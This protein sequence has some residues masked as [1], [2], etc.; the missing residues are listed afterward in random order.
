MDDQQW[1]TED[2][3]ET[4]MIPVFTDSLFIL[5]KTLR[6]KTVYMTSAE[7]WLSFCT[8]ARVTPSTTDNSYRELQDKPVRQQTCHARF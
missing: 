7:T 8:N 1:S 5:F 3:L 2:K 6:L 4:S